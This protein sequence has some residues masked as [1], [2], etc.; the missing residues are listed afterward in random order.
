MKYRMIILVCLLAVWS[1][2]VQA[3]L[4]EDFMK[5]LTSPIAKSTDEQTTASGL[6]EALTIGTGNAVGLLSKTNGYFENKLVKILLPKQIQK[7]ADF[8]G[9]IGYQQ[10]V[11]E[12]VLSMNRAAEAAAPEAKGI[13]VDAIKQM[14][15]EDAMKI[16]K[17]S[18]TAATEY[19]KS[20]TYGNLA[21]K[22]NPIISAS[23]ENYEVT[24][25][26]NALVGSYKKM[27]PF[28]SLDAVDLDRYVTTRAL[29]G[30]YFM[31]GEEEKKI[32]TNPAARVTELLKT[33]FGK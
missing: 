10:Q 17:G 31:I 12:F 11:D 16:L 20:K 32:R 28:M 8:L 30:L 33:V 9:K 19:L 13:F 27:V 4:L 24:S 15:F 14:T 7:A 26:Y 25:R 1:V 21:D 2:D 29:D 3:G 18:D 6:K 22:F 5:D 23:M